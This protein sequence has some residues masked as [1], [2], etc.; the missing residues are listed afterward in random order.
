MVEAGQRRIGY[1]TPL[2]ADG[3]VGMAEKEVADIVALEQ[4]AK[5]IAIFKRNQIHQG[6][7]NLER[8]MVHEN[9]NRRAICF[10]QCSP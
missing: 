10:R 5:S 1:S 6:M 4:V 7:V 9:V 3:A 8:R 2:A